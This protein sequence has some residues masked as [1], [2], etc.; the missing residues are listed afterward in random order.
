MLL[1][2]NSV[3]SV[4]EHPSKKTSC[5][6]KLPDILGIWVFT[7]VQVDCFSFVLWCRHRML[8]VHR[9]D[10]RS[11]RQQMVDMVLATE[12]TKHFEHL[13][14]FTSVINQPA[15]TDEEV[16]N[17]CCKHNPA[18]LPV[19]AVG[20]LL[21]LKR[22]CYDQPPPRGWHT[23]APVKNAEAR[24]VWRQGSLCCCQNYAVL[25][26]LPWRTVDARTTP[27]RNGLMDTL[28]W[29]ASENEQGQ[30]VHQ[31]QK[32]AFNVQLFSV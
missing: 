13:N 29:L 10:Y 24:Y 27:V 9:D 19:S 3:L 16:T 28:S 17:V 8:C 11:L 4:A 23:G 7:E 25:V 22:V 12:M 14:R 30:N 6:Q 20:A 31:I 32:R 2:P 26:I 21:I 18:Y 1:E 15:Q 5:R